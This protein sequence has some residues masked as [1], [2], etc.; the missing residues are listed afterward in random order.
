MAR[1][2]IHPYQQHGGVYGIAVPKHIDFGPIR[3]WHT[4]EIKAVGDRIT[5]TVDGEVV[6]DVNIREITQGHN[7]A[8]DGSNNNPYTLDHNNHPGLYNKEGYISFCGHGPGLKFRNIR[9]LDLS[10]K[11]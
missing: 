10:K 7:V 1:M 3:Q 2:C 6:T 5:V 11:K 4:E 9:V 8:P